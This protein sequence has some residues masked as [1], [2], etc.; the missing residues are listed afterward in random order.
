MATGEVHNGIVQDRPRRRSLE[1]MGH[2]ALK[3]QGQPP[4]ID[5][6]ESA[7]EAPEVAVNE[8]SNG[9]KLQKHDTHPC[10]CW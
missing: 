10:S 8:T 4:G 5:G 9:T 1:V 7:D 3:P 2:A 6:I